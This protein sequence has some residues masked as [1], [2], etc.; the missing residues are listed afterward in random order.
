VHSVRAC[1]GIMMTL[2][3]IAAS[4]LAVGSIGGAGVALDHLHVAA[5]DFEQYI[6]AQLVSDERDYVQELKKD[7]RDITGALIKDPGEEY[8]VEARAEL[9]DELCE[10]REDDRLCKDDE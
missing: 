5:E 1:V 4:V 3:Q 10:L 2:P 6:Q 7:I 8:L 9:I